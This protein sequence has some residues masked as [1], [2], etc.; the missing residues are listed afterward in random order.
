MRDNELRTA[1]FFTRAA[2]LLLDRLI[3]GVLLFLPRTINAVRTL[4]GGGVSRAVL[5]RFTW[6]DIVLW[7]IVTAYFVVFTASSGS[8]LGK[9]AL[10]ITVVTTQGKKP[11]WMTA[12]CRESFGRYLSSLLCIGYLLCLVDTEEHRALH[13]RICDTLVVYAPSKEK[14]PA[15]PLPRSNGV[16]PIPGLNAPAV[17]DDWYAPNR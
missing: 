17:T 6:T 13:D 7:V 12:L 9:K 8:T 14:R 4:A 5:F 11:D 1:P 2:A 3:L 10:G 16:P 15:P